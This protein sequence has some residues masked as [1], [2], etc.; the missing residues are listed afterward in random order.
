MP[1]ISKY[2]AFWYLVEL[3]KE[4]SNTLYLARLS[5]QEFCLHFNI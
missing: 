3:E 1:Y 5:I 4:K 2:W